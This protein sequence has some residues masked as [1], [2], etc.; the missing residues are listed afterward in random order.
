MHRPGGGNILL[1]E[2]VSKREYISLECAT[3][4]PKAVPP[5]QASS[6]GWG[7]SSVILLTVMLMGWLLD[8][9]TSRWDHLVSQLLVTL[10]PAFRNSK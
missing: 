6:L 2:E 8:E 5:Q 1:S 4:I 3:S 10:L 9:R 7:P